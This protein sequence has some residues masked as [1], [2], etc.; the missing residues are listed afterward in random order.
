VGLGASARPTR[1]GNRHPDNTCQTPQT[2]GPIKFIF[3]PSTLLEYSYSENEHIYVFVQK[4]CE[5]N[6]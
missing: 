4:V 1:A 6:I 3:L 2:S 5:S